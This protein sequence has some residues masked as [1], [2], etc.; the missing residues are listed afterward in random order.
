MKKREVKN[1]SVNL[2]YVHAAKMK[3]THVGCKG[4][5]KFKGVRKKRSKEEN[6]NIFV[7][8]SLSKLLH[9]F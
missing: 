3:M 1:V 7:L 4:R 5:E 9:A 6:W 8:A 2:T